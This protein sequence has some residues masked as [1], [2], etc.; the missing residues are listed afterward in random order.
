MS[1]R[2]PTPAPITGHAVVRL[3]NGTTY[4]GRVRYDGRAVT[5]SMSF[6]IIVNGI[7]EHRPPKRRTLPLHIIRDIIWDDDVRRVG[8]DADTIP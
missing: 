8:E 3:K 4:I 5:G 1:P 7:V 2:A 6:R